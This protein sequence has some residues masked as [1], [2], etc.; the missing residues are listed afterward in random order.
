MKYSIKWYFLRW[1]TGLAYMV[2]GLTGF[3]TLGF[4]GTSFNLDALDA[5]LNETDRCIDE[6]ISD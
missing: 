3:L 2:D 6:S 1:I 5:F 4:W